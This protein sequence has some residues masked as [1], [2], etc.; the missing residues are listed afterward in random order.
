MFE[1]FL[2][3]V[4]V[5]ALGYEIHEV[6]CAQAEDVHVIERQIA[7]NTRIVQQQ[8]HLFGGMLHHFQIRAQVV[9]SC[10]WVILAGESNRGALS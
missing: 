6:T 5:Q 8:V 4:V 9:S 10:C 2:A 7:R 1:G 3:L